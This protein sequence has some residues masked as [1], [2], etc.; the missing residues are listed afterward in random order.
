MNQNLENEYFLFAVNK[1][2]KKQAFYCESV[3]WRSKCFKYQDGGS[4][5]VVSDFVWHVMTHEKMEYTFVICIVLCY[6]T[7][8]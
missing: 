5:L 7:R 8:G 6:N 4:Y 1:M 2:S 3:A